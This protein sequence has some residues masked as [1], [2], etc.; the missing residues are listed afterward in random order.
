MISHCL[1]L[2]LVTG[3]FEFFE[4]EIFD[5]VDTSGDLEELST[6]HRTEA[7]EFFEDIF[8]HRL[9]PSLTVCRDR[10]TM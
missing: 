6:S 9:S 2:S 8:L 4:T 5:I 1:D 3:G 7:R 10:K